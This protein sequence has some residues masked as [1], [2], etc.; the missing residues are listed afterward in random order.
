MN[1]RVIII[2]ALF[3]LGL[4]ASGAYLGYHYFST[5]GKTAAADAEPKRF[6]QCPKCHFEIACGPGEDKKVRQCPRCGQKTGSVLEVIEKTSGFRSIN[7]VVPISVFGVTFV[8][9]C[10]YCFFY[11]VWPTY[12]KRKEAGGYLLFRCRH[13]GRRYRYHVSQAGTPVKC[14]I[15][16][17]PMIYPRPPGPSR[18]QRAGSTPAPGPKPPGATPGAKPQSLPDKK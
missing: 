15:C 18:P 14:A 3:L 11:F 12:Q 7:P 5:P 1:L 13:C 10:V 4:A 16:K 9:F 17:N 8:A 6:L 2:G